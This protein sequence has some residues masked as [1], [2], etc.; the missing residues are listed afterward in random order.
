MSAQYLS[1]NSA[2]GGMEFVAE[3]SAEE[4]Q[5]MLEKVLPLKYSWCI[6]EQVAQDKSGG[7]YYVD[8]T[9]EV[10]EFA[11]VQDFW[12]LWNHIP[13]PSQLVE[14]AGSFRRMV[15]EQDS[16]QSEI[17]ALMI[18]RKGIKPQW[19]DPANETGGHFQISLKPPGGRDGCAAG[20]IDEYWN[21]VVLGVIGATVEPADMVTGLRLVDKLA[22]PKN[23]QCIKIEVWFRDADAAKQSM[24]RRS[25]ERCL[26]TKL[27][28]TTSDALGLNLAAKS[29]KKGK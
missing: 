10:A 4:Q 28:G 13:Q 14:G 7:E 22:A 25:V 9:R 17:G 5:D 11:T 24:L 12:K 8:A 3:G 26:L 27:D 23:Q 21:N 16:K 18:F 20:Q 2:A 6:W 1:F 15:R 19:E 29:H